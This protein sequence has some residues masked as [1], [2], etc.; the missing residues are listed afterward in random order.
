MLGQVPGASDDPEQP[1]FSIAAPR[2]SRTQVVAGSGDRLSHKCLYM[3]SGADCNT[4]SRPWGHT[5]EDQLR[6]HCFTAYRKQLVLYSILC[7]SLSAT[8]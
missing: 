6:P 1:F 8:G 4:R 3:V 7:P 5:V 2:G